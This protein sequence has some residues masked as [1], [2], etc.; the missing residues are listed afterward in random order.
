MA[1]RKEVF[2]TLKDGTQVDRYTLVNENGVS[3]SFT[4]LGGIW[5]TMV[6]PDKDGNMEDI[7][8]GR[9]MTMKGHLGE[10]VGRNANRIGNASLAIRGVT[11]ALAVNSG[12]RNNLHSGPDY[13]GTRLWDAQVEEGDL[14]TRITFSL[15]RP[16]LSGE[17]GYCG[18]L[19]PYG[20]QQ[21]APGLPYDGRCGYHCQFYQPCLFQYGR[22]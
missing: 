19:Y 12:T 21:P 2:G 9:Y 4:N 15:R 20:R 22:P 6:V 18:E 5:L 11:Y 14:G 10:I 7:L 13:Y 17:R 1:W 3:A 8:L 16:G